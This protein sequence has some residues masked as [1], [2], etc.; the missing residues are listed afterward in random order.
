[1]LGLGSGSDLAT[2]LERAFVGLEQLLER[3]LLATV[4]S[5]MARLHLNL[6]AHTK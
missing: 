5:R 3:A 4:G 2:V 6:R 1:M